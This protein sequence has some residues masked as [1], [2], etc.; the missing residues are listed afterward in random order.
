MYALRQRTSL[1][2]RRQNLIS[3]HHARAPNL[4]FAL[5]HSCFIATTLH[6]SSLF[7]S[8]HIDNNTRPGCHCSE[9]CLSDR[10][11]QTNDPSWT[12]LLATPAAGQ[13]STGTGPAPHPACRSSPLSLIQ[14]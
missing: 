6:H 14:G 8:P 3:S 7:L 1:R 10:H 13:P 2:V 5:S 11:N 4:L 12:L 9:S